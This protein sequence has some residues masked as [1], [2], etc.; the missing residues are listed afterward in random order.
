MWCKKAENNMDYESK[1][2]IEKLEEQVKELVHKEERRDAVRAGTGCEIVSSLFSILYDN[3]INTSAIYLSIDNY[4]G[5]K[6]Y[7]NWLSMK[8]LEKLSSFLSG[9]IKEIKK[10]RGR[11]GS[12]L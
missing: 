1:A 7:S 5:K 2:R 11:G 3:Q 8:E 10:Q 12:N 6:E 9:K 4:N